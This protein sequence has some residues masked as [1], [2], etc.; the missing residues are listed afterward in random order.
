MTL[1]VDEKPFEGTM[2]S[3]FED[4]GLYSVKVSMEQ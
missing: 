2:L 1:F 3:I 4:E